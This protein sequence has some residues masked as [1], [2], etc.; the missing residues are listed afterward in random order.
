MLELVSSGIRLCGVGLQ[1]LFS[2]GHIFCASVYS[3]HT[4][5]KGSCQ[6]GSHIQ[7]ST[8]AGNTLTMFL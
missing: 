5:F 6:T 8:E 2:L 7:F 3:T 4:L 1:A